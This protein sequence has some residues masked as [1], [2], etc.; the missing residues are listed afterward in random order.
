MIPGNAKIVKCPYCGTKKELFTMLSG[1]TFGA[2]FWSDNKRVA[3]ML[4]MVSPVQ[5]CPSCGK[6]YEEVKNR[7]GEVNSH[8]FALGELTFPEWKEAYAQFQAEGVDDKTLNNLRFWLIQSYNDYFYRSKEAPKPS[9][10]DFEFFSKTVVEFIDSFNWNKAADLLMKAELYREANMMQECR[11]VLDS[12]P[13]DQ[14]NEDH[15]GIFE[16]IRLR[17]EKN[18]HVVFQLYV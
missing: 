13:F 2:T 9:E 17:M 14:L 15:M 11:Q 18:D 7:C 5:K 8:S 4:P 10:E 3:P 12:I 1:N 16:G 6:Y